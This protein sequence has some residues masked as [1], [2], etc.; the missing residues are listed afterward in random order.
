MTHQR[1]DRTHEIIG[2]AIEVHREF[3]PG[4]LESSYEMAFAKEL[5]LAGLEARRQVPLPLIYKGESLECGYRI[6]LLIEGAVIVEVKA[7]DK[8]LPIHE[9]Q[10]ISYLKLAKI[11]T[12]LLINFNVMHLRNGVRRFSV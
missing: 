9:A 3:G 7:V 6:D 2:C 5:Q 8:L 10:L 11:R 4:L 12:G 1:S